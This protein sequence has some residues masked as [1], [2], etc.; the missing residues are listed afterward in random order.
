MFAHVLC[1]CTLCVC[2]VY[3]YLHMCYVCVCI[4]VHVV[5]VCVCVC[6]CMHACMHVCVHARVCTCVLLVFVCVHDMYV[7]GKKIIFML[8]IL[9]NNKDSLDLMLQKWRLQGEQNSV[10][11]TDYQVCVVS[12]RNISAFSFFPWAQRPQS[13]SLLGTGNCSVRF[14]LTTARNKSNFYFCP[15]TLF[16]AGC[17]HFLVIY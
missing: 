1:M 14:L 8:C 11:P 4:H 3:I 16:S 13:D 17:Y 10:S 6:A 7:K 2:T 12:S 5:C 9:M 15:H